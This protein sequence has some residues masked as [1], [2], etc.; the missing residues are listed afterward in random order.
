[1]FESVVYRP[2]KLHLLTQ[3]KL[4]AE[5]LYLFF[6]VRKVHK[7]CYVVTKFLHIT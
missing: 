1:M 4:K 3:K 2:Q 5:W 6:L 7:S